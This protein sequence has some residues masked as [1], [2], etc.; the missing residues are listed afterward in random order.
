VGFTNPH[1]PHLTWQRLHPIPLR[2][3]AAMAT[4]SEDEADAADMDDEFLE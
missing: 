1:P 2:I 3:A 4:A